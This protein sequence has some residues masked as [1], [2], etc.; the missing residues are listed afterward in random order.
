LLWFAATVLLGAADFV[1]GQELAAGAFLVASPDS[2]DPH[3]A[4]TVILLVRSNQTSAVG[5]IINRPTRIRLSRIFQ[6]PK[7]S[8]TGA[9]PVYEGGPVGRTGVLALLRASSR[10]EG[11]ERVFADVCLVSSKSLLEKTLAAGVGSTRLR[12]YLGYCGWSAGQLRNEVKAGAWYV[13][14]GEAE[15]VFDA[16]PESVWRQ[17]I[18]Q[19]AV[20]HARLRRVSNERELICHST[21][22]KSRAAVP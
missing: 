10:P 21:Y 17:L 13:A 9:E 4:E 14:R 6:L 19:V 7:G 18:R 11:A 5:L 2:P 1:R 16:H 12:V 8:R 22:C 15:R 3:F 20:S